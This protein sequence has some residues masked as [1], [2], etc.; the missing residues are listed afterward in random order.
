M[1]ARDPL[2]RGKTHPAIRMNLDNVRPGRK[3]IKEE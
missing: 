3:L 1:I 2:T